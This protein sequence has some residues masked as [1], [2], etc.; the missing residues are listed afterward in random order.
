M[1]DPTP[2][3]EVVNSQCDRCAN[4]NKG[5]FTCEA[6]PEGIPTI[7]FMNVYDHNNPYDIGEDD[8][9][10]ITFVDINE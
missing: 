8:D 1:Y 10:G 5:T 4:R 2:Q 6:F 3:I 9:H 7:I